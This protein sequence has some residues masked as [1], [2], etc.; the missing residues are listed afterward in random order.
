MGGAKRKKKK[1]R[2]KTQKQKSADLWAAGSDFSLIPSTTQGKEI[3]LTLS[4]FYTITLQ[5][6]RKK[7]FLLGPWKQNILLEFLE[8]SI[9]FQ[10]L[11]LVHW[12]PAL[13]HISLYIP[14]SLHQTRKTPTAANVIS[15]P[16]PFGNLTP[17]LWRPLPFMHQLPWSHAGLCQ[18][19]KIFPFKVATQWDPAV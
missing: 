9:S 18:H 11:L 6:S 19:L 5:S 17:D 3:R 7:Q 2:N 1:K 15:A 4:W 12:N 10:L 13:V 8:P 14:E 16:W